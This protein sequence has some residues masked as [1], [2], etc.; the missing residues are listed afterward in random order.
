MLSINE[1]SPAINFSASDGVNKKFLKKRVFLLEIRSFFMLFSA[2]GEKLPFGVVCVGLEDFGIYAFSFII[3]YA[4][5]QL[6]I[7][8]ENR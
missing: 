2:N 5:S 8:I 4:H 1:T 3:N 6:E 7:V